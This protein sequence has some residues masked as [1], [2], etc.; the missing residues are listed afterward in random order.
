MLRIQIQ[1]AASHLSSNGMQQCLATI[2]F[3]AGPPPCFLH[4][5]TVFPASP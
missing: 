2:L 1:T 4:H 3:P 5:K